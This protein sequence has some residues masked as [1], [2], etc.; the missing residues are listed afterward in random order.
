M[1]RRRAAAVELWMVVGMVLLLVVVPRWQQAQKTMERPTT[2]QPRGALVMV[3]MRVI[4]V[5]VQRRVRVITVVFESIATKSHRPS[6]QQ[7]SLNQHRDQKRMTTPR[8][9]LDVRSL[10]PL[11]RKARTM[12]MKM[13]GCR[14]K[15]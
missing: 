6:H 12:R 15:G 4:E 3:L 11:R 1:T 13:R 7:Q 10:C 9:P 8:R 5:G 2:R 14:S